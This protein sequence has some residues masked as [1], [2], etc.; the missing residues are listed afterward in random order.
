MEITW[1]RQL[2]MC[3]RRQVRANG[4]YVAM[5][6]DSVFQIAD[7]CKRKQRGLVNQQCVSDCR[8]KRMETSWPCY[9]TVSSGLQ[10]LAN[11]NYEAVSTD[12]VFH[13]AGRGEWKLRGRVN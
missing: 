1:P 2:T 5:S 12:R 3:S 10:V 13:I 6:T 7:P 11:G 8:S 9:L 4:N